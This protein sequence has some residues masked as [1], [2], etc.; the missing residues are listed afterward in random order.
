MELKD[1][2]KDSRGKIQVLVGE[3][4]KSCPE[5]TLFETEAGKARGGCVHDKSKEILVVLEGTICYVYG[6]D[7][8]HIVLSK[9]EVFTTGP[10]IP[11]FFISLTD[12]IVAE[13]GPQLEEK[14]AKY[15]PFR[16][17]VLEING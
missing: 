5:I 2:N 10:G 4:L 9:G 8:K 7:Q 13:W 11:H 16:K 6:E 3:M 12:S 14:A 1:I 17:I 15:E